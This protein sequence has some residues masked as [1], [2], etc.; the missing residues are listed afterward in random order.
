MVHG[1]I[2]GGI[3]IIIYFILSYQIRKQISILQ[4]MNRIIYYW[5][6]MTILTMIWEI[7]FVVNYKSV[8]I[9]AQQLILNNTHVWTNNYDI[10]Y[11][12][13]WKLS[14]IFYAEYGAYADKDYMLLYNDWSRVIESSHASFCGL[15][16][17]MTLYHR[18]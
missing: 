8:N 16:A 6:T 11:I 3:E 18:V 9:L 7:F 15:F 5:M 17:F 4:T 1:W 13:P 14:H 2:I 10:T 12:L